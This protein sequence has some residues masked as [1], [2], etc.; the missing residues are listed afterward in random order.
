VL[1]L[2]D[3]D[4]PLPKFPLLESIRAKVAVAKTQ[5]SSMNV[6]AKF[7]RAASLGHNYSNL[8]LRA[9]LPGAKARSRSNVA[10]PFH[11]GRSW[12]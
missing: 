3:A 7:F 1:A 9:R 6:A 10:N 5:I 8:V 2:A 4:K 12:V 11:S